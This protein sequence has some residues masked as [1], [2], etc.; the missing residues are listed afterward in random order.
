MVFHRSSTPYIQSGKFD[1][2]SAATSSVSSLSHFQ[3]LQ[4][5]DRYLVTYSDIA[6]KQLMGQSMP[7]RRNMR[8]ATPR[9]SNMHGCSVLRH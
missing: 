8:I 9:T 7:L 4:S 6:S 2:Q 5:Q 3:D 1:E